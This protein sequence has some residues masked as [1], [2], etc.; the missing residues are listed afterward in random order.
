MVMPSLCFCIGLLNTVN[1]LHV[2]AIDGIGSL[3]RNPQFVLF[4]SHERFLVLFI[5]CYAPND[6][7]GGSKYCFCPFICLSV[8]HVHSE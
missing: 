2:I 8:Y 4:L 3:S 1:Y 7:E 6:R 5:T